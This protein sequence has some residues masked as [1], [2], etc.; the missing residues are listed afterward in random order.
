MHTD[1]KMRNSSKWS[2]CGATTSAI[3]LILL[4][5]VCNVQ[6]GD[7]A[8]QLRLTSQ[9]C[10]LT[11]PVYGN[12]FDFAGLRSD[13]AHVLHGIYEDVFEFNVCGN[14]SHTCHGQS[15][16]AACL[17]RNGKEFVLGRQEE[18]VYD[19]G[20]MYFHYT[21]GE[22]CENG[23]N[24]DQKFELI[25]KLSCDYTL[26]EKPM[27]VIAYS[28]DICVFY[29]EYETQLACLP[30]PPKLESNSCSVRFSDAGDTF[31]LM[32]LSDDNHIVPDR[33]GSNFIINICKPVL[34]GK[35]AM[36]P[37]G[38]SI[39]R[40]L[41]N[42]NDIKQRY[43][44]VGNVQ[45]KPVFEDGKLL[46]R[47][48][49]STPCEH[50]ASVNYT[51]VINF[52]CDKY[53]TNTHPSYMGLD[54]TGCTYQFNLFTPLACQNIKPCT[55]IVTGEEHLD[56][57]PL[58][59]LAPRKLTKGG[60]NY[61]LAVCA[62]AGAPCLTNG[63]ACY[64]ENGQS[65][66]LGDFNTHLRF[67]QS[68]AP[69]LLYENGAKC[70]GNRL[71]STKIEF[72][73]ANN[74]TKD[75]T[76]D[77][78]VHVIED[79]NCQLI[80][81]YQTKYACQQQIDCRQKVYNEDSIEELFDLTPL[82]NAKDNYEARVELPAEQ[83]KELPKATKFFLNVCRPL[84]PK[85]QLGCA[86]GSSACMAKMSANGAPEEEHSLG[87]PMISLS[88][89]NRTDAELLYPKGDPCPSDKSLKLTSSIHFK[90]NMRA[91]R[92]QPVL[93]EMDKCYYRF[94]WATSLICPP[95][96]CIF[97]EDSCEIEHDEAGK[98]FSFK[99]APFTNNGQLEI[100]YNNSKL[101]VNICGPY[102]KAITDYSQDL[103]N[104]YFSHKLPGCGK[105]G[106]MNVQLRLICSNQTEP[107]TVITEGTQ[108]SLLHVQ[109]T[110]SICQFL[111]L[112]AVTADAV[113]T[114]KA[115]PTTASTHSSA[116]AILGI[117]LSVTFCV[118][119]VGLF[120]FSP[121]RRNRVRRIF[122]RSSSAVRYSRV[123]SNEEANLLLEPN[124]EF[125]ESDDDMLL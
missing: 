121:A 58:S 61:T 11:E 101:L 16:V 83:L 71:W 59:S 117:I 49:S 96:E 67:N 46:M 119:C 56:L 2:I 36:C 85:Y 69:Y 98:R 4:L 123:Q 5:L 86:G 12:K 53:V 27:R 102:R 114:T 15:N 122:R 65:I 62:G 17:K 55:A 7:D 104:L 99:N 19:N 42:Q 80:I 28:S 34:Y 112:D 116:T 60:K 48:E 106:M 33:A 107:S 81:Q 95:H 6:A 50:N 115:T 111:G 35:N 70:N 47:H 73:C 89:F 22:T 125:T 118:T 52:Y 13:L 39:C 87:F 72:V 38:S 29:I 9:N 100:D 91:G 63:G 82:I 24:K 124:G 113:T 84:V 57:S 37:P 93:H 77:N 32:P 105:D 79:A 1:A 25:V 14:L 21:N 75:I 64:E 74:H 76:A 30:I 31:D 78:A 109:R 92:G 26:D 68:G 44:N 41:Q 110:P 20:Q 51:S 23:T 40:R 43:L 120:A 90:C 45:T 103:V 3:C 97:H 54:S 18:L 66:N 94:D 8:N 88:V 10:A 108:C